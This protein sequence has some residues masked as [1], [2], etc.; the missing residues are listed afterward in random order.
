LTTEPDWKSAFYDAY[1]SSGQASDSGK[2]AAELFRSRKAFLTHIIATYLPPDRN[3]R[4]LDLA[5]GPGALLYFL[6]QA[7]YRDIAG[8]DVSAEQIAVAARL[9]IA[10]ATSATLEQFLAAQPPA[11]ADA[12]LAID[13]LEHLTRPQVMTVLAMVRRVLKPGG[14]CV[15]HVPNGEGIYSSRIRYGDFTHELAFTQNSARQV[16]R[17]AGFS[18]VKCYE[19]KPRVHGFVSLARR[20]IWD[21]GTLPDRLLW[22]AETGTPGAILSQNM[23]VEALLAAQPNPSSLRQPALPPRPRSNRET[24]ILMQAVHRKPL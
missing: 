12:V 21:V 1:V 22:A 3:S 2:P 18:Q 16:F 9:G 8:V 10:S 23:M 4:I 19:D 7:G 17:V 6:E 20:I 5:C 14:R 15:A 13:I 11:S 24:G